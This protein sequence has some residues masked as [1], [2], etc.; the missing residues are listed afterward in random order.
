MIKIHSNIIIGSPSDLAQIVNSVHY[1]IN[2]STNLNNM[3]VH[4]NYLN[5]NITQFTTESLNILIS[6][7]DFINNKILLNQNV[8][9][10]CDSGIGHSLIVGMFFVMKLLNL[11]YYNTYHNIATVHKI[12]SYEFYSGLKYYEPYIIKYGF[13]EKMD[14]S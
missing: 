2:C 13:G 8:F 12:N 3:M 10:L 5:L 1:I 14:H 9:L 6:V 4:S 11:N 7:Y